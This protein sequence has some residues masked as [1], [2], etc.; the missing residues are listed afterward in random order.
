MSATS[1]VNIA[2]I[3]KEQIVE[4]AT[5][6]I[7][8][9][10]IQNLK[11]SA[12]EKRA[13]MARGQLT[14]YFKTK[15]EILLAVFD[16]VLQRMHEKGSAEHDACGGCQASGWDWVKRLM[17]WVLTEPPVSPEFGCLQHTFLAQVGHREDFRQRLATLYEEWRT[18]MTRGIAGDQAAGRLTRSVSPRAVA[19]LV[20][21][22]LHGLHM[23]ALADPAAFDPQELLHLCLDM[24]GSYLGAGSDAP[25]RR[26]DGARQPQAPSGNGRRHRAVARGKR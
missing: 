11:L 22:L 19:T 21:A 1:R 14:Y 6:V 2:S 20:Q 17:T 10:G 16:R 9:E 24:L 18:G 3:R 4:A 23:Q 8:Q 5:A 25:R 13:G 7:T 15:E 12:I 26:Q